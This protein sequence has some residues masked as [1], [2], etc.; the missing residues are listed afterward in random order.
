MQEPLLLVL[1][2]GSSSLKF[3]L[4]SLYQS[5][6]RPVYRGAVEG[7]GSG[8]GRVWLRSATRHIVQDEPQAVP[9]QAEAIQLVAAKLSGLR[10]PKLSA[11]GHRIVHGGPL[12]REHQRI[13]PQVLEQLEAVSYFAP[14]HIPV[15]LSLIREAERLFPGIL[16]FACFDTAFHRSLPEAAARFPLPDKFWELGVRRY[17]FHGLSCESILHALDQKV[18]PRMIVAHLG[19]GASITAVQNGLSVDTTMGLTPTGGI[20]MGTRSG[21]LDPGVLLY[22]LRTNGSTVEKLENLLDR[23]SGLLGISGISSDMRELHR[24][25]DSRPSQLAIEMFARSARKA[26]AGFVAVLGGLDLLVFTGGIGERDA[27]MRAKICHGLQFFGLQLDEHSNE[28]NL[29]TISSAVSQIRV[30]I[31]PSEEE[32]QIARHSY[33]LLTCT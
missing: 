12:L 31:F 14:L 26:I 7:I 11:I 4:F 27:I 33:R 30:C 1:N 28:R 9:E 20:V 16:Q 15:E 2:S 22:I 13:T 3:G 23:E 8:E 18:P 24:R 29:G 21:D 10:L 6:V 19:N 17:G 32:T 25:S 5:E